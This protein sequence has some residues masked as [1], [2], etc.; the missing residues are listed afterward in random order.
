VRVP[1]DFVYSPNMTLSDIIYLAGG[2]REEAAEGRI[3]ISRLDIDEEKKTQ[4]NIAT[5][6]VDRRLVLEGQQGD[7]K[8]KPYDQIF[9]RRAPEF[10]LQQN[11]TLGG[12]VVYPGTYTLTDKQESIL[13]VIQRAGGLTD[14]AFPK[15]ATL[16]RM[17]D[18]LGRV[19]LNLD[20]AIK[21]PDSRFNYVLKAGD[22]INIPK[23][24]DLVSI[25]GAVRYPNIDKL[26][27]VNAPHHKGR[28]ANF[29]VNKYGAGVDRKVKRGR[30]NL[31]TVVNSNGYVQKTK[32]YGLFKIYPKV[33][34]GAMVDVDAKPKRERK[35]EGEDNEE[36]RREW[37]E[38]FSTT[39]AQATSVLTLILL[40]NRALVQ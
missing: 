39:V 12:E 25:M 40:A 9:V 11:I 38:I 18:S 16:L 7:F 10:E 14:A 23:H 26:K 1:G 37:T 32:N 13:S 33:D 2:L 6:R 3:E 17:E 8:I 29:Y 34:P 35:G 19:I 28:R 20:R 36:R 31:I 27:K 15:G 4:V 24:K 30:K 22:R 5:V 21:N